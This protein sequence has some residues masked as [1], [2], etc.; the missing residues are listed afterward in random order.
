MDS[1]HAITGEYLIHF[2]T[3]QSTHPHT[4]QDRANLWMMSCKSGFITSPIKKLRTLPEL[5][6]KIG[7]FH[8][9]LFLTLR[10]EER[11]EYG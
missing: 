5:Y 6:K 4:Q 7:H 10:K 11:G 3:Y 9:L 2:E 1:V 8:L